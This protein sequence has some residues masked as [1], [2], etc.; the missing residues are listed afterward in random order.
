MRETYCNTVTSEYM[1]IAAPG[2]KEWLQNRQETSRNKT[3]LTPVEKKRVMEKLAEAEAFA[4]HT[5]YVATRVFEGLESTVP[6][7]MVACW[8]G[9]AFRCSL[10]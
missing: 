8:R 10:R 3:E 6:P 2:Q 4:R 9:P 7:S 1:F 5:K